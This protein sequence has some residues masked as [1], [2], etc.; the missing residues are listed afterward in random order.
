MVCEECADEIGGI[1]CFEDIAEASTVLCF[2]LV[3]IL[4]VER[5]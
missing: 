3:L 5:G 2:R 1:C 4:L